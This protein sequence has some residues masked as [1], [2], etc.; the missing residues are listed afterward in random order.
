MSETPPE[1]QTP[2]GP[3]GAPGDA[4]AM[5]V[6]NQYVKD[7]SF[8]SPNA[9]EMVR[10]DLPP[11]AVE[12][13]V[14]VNARGL[15]SDQYE[16]ELSCSATATRDGKTVFVVETNYAGLF[17]IQNVPQEQIEGVL[18]VTAP[19]LLF[20]FARQVIASATADGGF[21]PLRLEPL[22]FAGMYTM[23]KARAA[24]GGEPPVGHA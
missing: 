17:L 11:P 1:P 16:V 13:A 9:P 8:E 15:G 24:Q 12:V 23:Q 5:R 19:Q 22:D 10:P 3:E 21:N 6:L 2:Q 20:P 7:L 4:P 18:L 14:D